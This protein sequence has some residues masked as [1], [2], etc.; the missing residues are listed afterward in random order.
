MTWGRQRRQR[1]D[2]QSCFK[3]IHVIAPLLAVE[4]RTTQSNAVLRGE[5][6][7]QLAINSR[8]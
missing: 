1:P 3:W 8:G 6:Q 5:L 2:L 4:T 7:S